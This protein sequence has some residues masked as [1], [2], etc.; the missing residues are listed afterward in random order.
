[1]ALLQ[2]LAARDQIMDFNIY[3]YVPSFGAGVAFI[4]IFSVLSIASLALVIRSRLFWLVVVTIGGIG[5]I[6]GCSSCSFLE[7]RARPDEEDRGR[8]YLGR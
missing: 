8:P 6:L 4:T 5:E 1:M 2:H 3:G 7:A